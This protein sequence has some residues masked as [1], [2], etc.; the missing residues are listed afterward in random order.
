[1]IIITR[2]YF[3][4]TSLIVSFAFNLFFFIIFLVAGYFMN[5]RNRFFFIFNE[6]NLNFY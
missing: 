1:M 3:S 6:I 4:Q 5:G 2:I